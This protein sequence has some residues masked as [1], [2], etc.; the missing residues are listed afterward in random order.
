MF[1][2]I[3]FI[4]RRQKKNTLERERDREKQVENKFGP[5]H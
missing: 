1:A 4:D 5:R 2:G 3:F